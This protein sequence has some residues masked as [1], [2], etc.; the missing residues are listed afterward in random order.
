MYKDF[1]K[2][3]K[4]FSLSEYLIKYFKQ[5][6]F[7]QFNETNKKVAGKF[8]D[9]PEVKQSLNLLVRD[10]KSIAVL[11]MRRRRMKNRKNTLIVSVFKNDNQMRNI[12]NIIGSKKHNIQCR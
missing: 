3:Q 11:L 8:K 6:N 12:V 1:L 5:F 10:L 7:K 4:R 2:D 9:K